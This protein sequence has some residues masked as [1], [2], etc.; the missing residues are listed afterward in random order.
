MQ[1]YSFIL[2]ALKFNNFIF[3]YYKMY[4]N[5]YNKFYKTLY[6]LDQTNSNNFYLLDLNFS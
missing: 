2:Q 6:E 4:I 1:F 3:F 5:L